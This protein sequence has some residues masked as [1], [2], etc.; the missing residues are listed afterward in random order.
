[1][2]FNDF[3]RFLVFCAPL[4]AN[5]TDQPCKFTKAQRSGPGWLIAST[6]PKGNLI[7]LISPGSIEVGAKSA[8]SLNKLARY[9]ALTGFSDYFKKISVPESKNSILIVKGMQVGTVTCD[10][11]FFIR[12]ELK[13]ANMSWGTPE[14]QPST[15]YDE[16]ISPGAAGKVDES[17]AAESLLAKPTIQKPS[18]NIIIED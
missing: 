15:K 7:Y 9:A 11:G 17:A 10:E 13:L 14:S 12:Y 3:L 16:L 18:S 2:I 8:Q 6:T 4:V 5:A 1:M